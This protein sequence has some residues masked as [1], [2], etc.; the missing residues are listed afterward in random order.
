MKL[1][2]PYPFNIR[3]YSMED[4]T[5]FFGTVIAL[6]FNPISFGC[7]EQRRKRLPRWKRKVIEI[8]IQSKNLEMAMIK[9]HLPRLLPIIMLVTILNMP[10]AVSAATQTTT[11]FVVS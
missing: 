10:L 11:T 9:T 1:L 6:I 7:A 2:H 4:L 8:I 5:L 3:R